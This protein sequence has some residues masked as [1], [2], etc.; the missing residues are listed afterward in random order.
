MGKLLE[1]GKLKKRTIERKSRRK[2]PGRIARKNVY[3][4]GGGGNYYMQI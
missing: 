3:V 2:T 4:M 1:K